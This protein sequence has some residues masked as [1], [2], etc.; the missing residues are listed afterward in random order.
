MLLWSLA[1]I[2]RSNAERWNPRQILAARELAI[3]ALKLGQPDK[4]N[5]QLTALKTRAAKCGGACREASD[6]KDAIDAIE[7]AQLGADHS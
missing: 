4:A 3:T 1:E 6:L 5:L 7:T 2:C